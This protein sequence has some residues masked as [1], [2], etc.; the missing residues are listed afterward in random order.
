MKT[1]VTQVLQERYS[2]TCIASAPVLEVDQDPAAF[3]ARQ[4]VT[5][6]LA[7]LRNA[8]AKPGVKL[9]PEG[10]VAVTG[11]VEEGDTVTV[12]DSAITLDGRTL[13]E[14]ELIG[15]SGDTGSFS[16]SLEVKKHENAWYVG[17]WDINI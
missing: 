5:R 2:Q 1:F 8:W 14:L 17:S 10:K 11:V 9:P 12:P 6:S 16:L 7:V 4:E 3:C 13:R 15:S